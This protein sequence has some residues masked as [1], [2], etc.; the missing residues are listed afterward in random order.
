MFIM[1]TK[2]TKAKAIV[3]VLA[4]GAVL[5]ALVFAAGHLYQGNEDTIPSPQNVSDNEDRV[6]YLA[7]WGW[8]V[9]PSAV[10]TLDLLLPEALSD[11]YGS[12]NELQA[13]NGMDLTAYCSKRVKRYT[14]TVLN[15]PDQA[16]GI[17][18]NLYLCDDTV[19]AGDILSTG[20]EGFISSL[21]YPK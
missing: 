13:E 8:E 1:T 18:A 16:E 7:G 9:D 17:Q 15:Y 5:C 21:H 6:S 2:L 14:Y 19:V 4:G 12:Y 11:S 20:A 10:E 3:G